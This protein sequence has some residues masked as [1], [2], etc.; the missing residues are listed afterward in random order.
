M[1][2]RD[3]REIV[4]AIKELNTELEIIRKSLTRI[5][6]VVAPRYSA[7]SRLPLPK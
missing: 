4:Q 5:E 2:D 6:D 1:N 7:P 3:L